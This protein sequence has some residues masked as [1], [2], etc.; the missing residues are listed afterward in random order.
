[1]VTRS[2]CKISLN[3]YEIHKCY[4][5]GLEIGICVSEESKPEAHKKKKG[6]IR[7]RRKKRLVLAEKI[8]A[9]SHLV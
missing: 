2:H 7:K 9:E 3:I 6:L 1:M 8:S 5:K 4:N